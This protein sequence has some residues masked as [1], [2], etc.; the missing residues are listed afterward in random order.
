VIPVLTA[1]KANQKDI[2][3]LSVQG[4]D[5]EELLS[6]EWLLTNER[7]SYAA[8]TVA[9]CN[10]SSY[11]GLLVGSLNPP[12]HRIMALSNC[13]EMVICGSQVFQLSTFEFD[14]RFAP[15]GW[16]HLREFR[17]GTAAVFRYDLGDSSLQKSVYLLRN[18]DTVVVEYTFAELPDPVELVVRPFVGL[19]DFHTV[20]RSYAPLLSESVGAGLLVR[21]NVPGS[22]ELLLNSP[23]MR[24]ETDAQWW[25]NFAY[26]V[27][28]S[29]GQEKHE[30]L[31]SPGFFKGR[32]E[33]VGRL[34]FWARL[35]E[36]LRDEQMP[37]VD[38]DEVKK[39]LAR[40]ESELRSKGEAGETTPAILRLA[41]DQFVVKRAAVG[42]V[43]STILAGFPWFADWGRDAFIALPGLLLVTGRHAEARSVLS[44]FAG[45]VDEGMIPN[46]FDD[47]SATAYFNSVDA[48]L[49]FIN[50]AFQ[51]LDVTGDR[52]AFLEELLPA[53]RWIV[54][55]YE[56]GTRFNIHSDEDGLVV[57]GDSDTQLTWMDAKCDGIAFTPR[58]GKAVEV[59][60]LWH[61]AL[62][63]LSEFCRGEGSRDAARYA[64]MADQAGRSF[65]RL[66]WNEAVG[67]LNDT[68]MPDGTVDAS[69]RPNQVF[70]VSLPYGPPLTRRQQ[71]AIVNVVER[72]L[73][74][75]HGLRTL[76]PQ[77][78]SY[79]GRYEGPLRRRDEA[80]H[81]GTVWP[82]LMGPFV[83]AY[84][85]VHD[86]SAASKEQARQWLAPLVRH[87]VED[88]CLGSVAEVFDGDVP[89]RPQGCLA[90]AWSVAELIRAL[91]LVGNGK[92]QPSRAATCP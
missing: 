63:R 71:Q 38:V 3:S 54:D 28:G 15:A 67:Y 7:G 66:F 92:A 12:A 52:A 40:R 2:V 27:N 33:R 44:T 37:M 5:I 32:I 6:K 18:S 64:A 29:R 81:Q 13:L 26:R 70:A 39:N 77:H 84:L 89:Q 56:N 75:P 62:C 58:W 25:F 74:T 16:V 10:T 55:A 17:R 41:A 82:Y 69:L 79:K 1:E 11:H 24:F 72:E 91:H 68:V 46:R 57:A 35:G 14:G 50:A 65:C 86:F 47:R 8:S 45:V 9:G 87:V 21:H 42:T 30:D 85:K 4:K 43:R 59:N 20:Q 19:R 31:W 61:N 60:A 90:Q 48:S 83:E 51:Y 80:Y 53:V 78:P 73:L 76:N 49:W 88:G 36:N 34:A 22:C 23:T